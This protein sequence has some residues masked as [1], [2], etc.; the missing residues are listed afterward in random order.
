MARAGSTGASDRQAP[1]FLGGQK[2]A[3]PLHF[4]AAMKLGGASAVAA[5]L[6]A[7]IAC[8]GGSAGPD[9]GGVATGD[10]GGGDGQV[11]T[12]GP[13]GGGDGPTSGADA[14]PPDASP[15]DAGPPD[16]RTTF[17]VCDGPTAD[18]ATIADAIAGVPAGATI[19]I[20]PGTWKERLVID[21]KPVHLLGTGGAAVTILDADHGGGAIAVTNTGGS[22]VTLEGLTIRNGVEPGD[23][24]GLHCADSVLV[25]ETC[26][27]AD[28]VAGNDGGGVW[29][30]GCTGQIHGSS[31]SGNRGDQGGAIA[32]ASGD[33]IVT[34]NQIVG[35]SSRERGGGLYHASDALIEGNLISGNASDWAGGGVFVFQHEPTFR[36]NQVL[37]NTSV[38]DGGGVYFHQ[39]HPTL[40]DNTIRGNSS[41]DDGGGVRMFESFCHLEG[42]LIEE[43]HATHDGGGARLSH[44]PC[45]VVDNTV[46]NNTAG[47]SGGGF[48]LDNDASVLTGGVISGNTAASYG[49][50]IH[51]VLA[52]WNDGG[53]IGIRIENNQAHRGGGIALQDNFQALTLRDLVVVG[54]QADHGGGL[55][56]RTTVFTLR[57]SV[58]ARNSAT[59]DGGA[60]WMG[61]AQPFPDACPCPATHT[62]S[63]IQ[64]V[65]AWNN[66]AGDGS[67]LWSDTPDV[68]T[69]EDSIFHANSG[70][71]GIR[72]AAATSGNT[73]A[74]P[75]WRY[76]DTLPASFAG[77]T[78]PGTSN[79]NKAVNPMLV[80]AAGGD[81]HLAAGS[82]CIDAADP[83]LQ[84]PDATRADMGRYG[85]PGAP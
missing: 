26:V 60:L 48:D 51:M 45:L 61:R 43:N 3:R 62:S 35:N 23:G 31:F 57:N 49:G 59:I 16:A 27:F 25:V 18:Y 14:A 42:N 56:S 39:G 41:G 9:G 20:C 33:L 7:G 63:T 1:G 76:D 73:P 22:G 77:M 21:D 83:S 24:G 50:G 28:N 19:A 10:A 72:I 64:F 69:F 52:P 82:P 70:P 71:T 37:D 17:T 6:C 68:Q 11:P 84:D 13:S 75:V 44:K 67:V 53:L 66:S 15:A 5:L 32:V 2:Q 55:H 8:T 4:A 40:V 79:G 29:A 47:A 65:T 46:R 12:D 54:N 74:A 78:A 81:F 34:G 80:D 58:F 38:N 36:D 85:G 30:D